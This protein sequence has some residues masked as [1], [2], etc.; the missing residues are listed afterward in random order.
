MITAGDW[1]GKRKDILG[2]LLFLLKNCFMAR[3]FITLVIS[4]IVVSCAG[5]GQ[6]GG[7]GTDTNLKYATL[8]HLTECKGY[9]LADIVNPWDTARLLHRYVLVPSGSEVP[10]GIPEGTLVR[11]PIDHIIV[12]SSVH[13]SIIDML[14]EAGRISGVCE[15]EYMTCKAVQKG[16]ADGSIIDCGN[17]VSPNIEKIA[18]A[19][20]QVIIASPFQNSTYGAAEKLG[21]PIIEAADYM[22]NLPLGR[23]EWVR[24]F[25][26]LLDRQDRADSLFRAAESDYNGVRDKVRKHLDSLG[27]D[28]H[29]PTLLAER[30]YGASWD[31]P[32]GNSYMVRIY[33]DAGAS[34]IFSG[35]TSSANVNMS[36]ENVLRQGIDA[37]IWVMKY[38]SETPMSYASLESEYHLYSQFKAFKERHIFGCNTAHSSYYDD[39]VLNPALILEDLAAVFHPDLYPGREPVYFKPLD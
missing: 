36:F 5:S 18:E 25:G 32:G 31:V 29:R 34:Y 2:E 8:L 3:I 11:T 37:D 12:Y 27:G 15:P 17:S 33:N 14:G 39:I 16:I 13:A 21:I 23:T 24:L 35:N 4:L 30:K 38:W 28:S 7:N 22:E 9:T 19:G 1:Y 26:A 10:D 20:G 6:K